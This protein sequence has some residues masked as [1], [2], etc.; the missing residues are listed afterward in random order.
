MSPRLS[1][2][3]RSLSHLRSSIHVT[4]I[5]IFIACT[6]VLFN[7]I[8]LRLSNNTKHHHG[9]YAN[10][11]SI[12]INNP[13]LVQVYGSNELRNGTTVFDASARLSLSLSKH[14]SDI[15]NYNFHIYDCMKAG[16]SGKPPSI[17]DAC[18][19]QQC[20][21]VFFVDVD[22]FIHDPRVDVIKFMMNLYPESVM[23]TGIDYYHTMK[24]PM[25]HF[26]VTRLW[27]TDSNT[28]MFVFDCGKPLS[29]HI[30]VE[31]ERLTHRFSPYNDDQE[32]FTLMETLPQYED[33]KAFVRDAF[34]LGMYSTIARHLSGPHGKDATYPLSTDDVK[35]N[36]K[37]LKRSRLALWLSYYWEQIKGE[38]VPSSELWRIRENQSEWSWNGPPFLKCPLSNN[39]SASNMLLKHGLVDH[40]KKSS[41]LLDSIHLVDKEG[42]LIVRNSSK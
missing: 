16:L 22:V 20:S 19:Q 1:F 33:R 3:S 17:W 41:N 10:P 30:L 11:E 7:Y 32:A 12:Q 26:G 35:K 25:Q 40:E 31:W 39:H 13:C 34:L 15:H 37:K 6:S 42:N 9:R 8:A 24:N 28:G 2:P 14:Y 23:M 5:L 21:H 38:A 27:R 4:T 36:L 29:R 18:Y